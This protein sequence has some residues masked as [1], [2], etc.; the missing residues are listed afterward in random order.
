MRKLLVVGCLV[1]SVA[2]SFAAGQAAGRE[3]AALTVQVTSAD[4]EVEEG[5][6]SLGTDATLMVKPGTPLYRFLVRRRGEQV[7]ITFGDAA[8]PA[9]SRLER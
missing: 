7:T 6:F 8:R 3:D 9:L 4:H 1:S 5:Y 2:G